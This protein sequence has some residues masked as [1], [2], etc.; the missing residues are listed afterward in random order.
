MTG[1]ARGFRRAFLLVAVSAAVLI[2]ARA[3]LAF[4]DVPTSYWDY[5]AIRYV[6]TTNTWM[7]DYGTTT[8]KP[9][10]HEI[11]EYLAR[12]LVEVYAPTEPI[13]PS[14]HFPDLPDSD[15]F[16][17]YANVVTKLGWMPKYQ[18]GNWAPG[19]LI[20]RTGFDKAMVLALG[21]TDE[22]NGLA[23]IHRDDGAKYTVST[24]FPYL[25]LARTLE[26]HFNHTT[27]SMDLEPS[28][29]MTRDEAAYS[30][31]FAK[32]QL[33][34]ELTT[35]AMFKDISLPTL[36]PTDPLQHSKLL[37]TQYALNQVGYPYIW[38][39]EWHS[40]SPSGYC[41]GYQPK[42]GFDC[43]GFAWWVLKKNESGYNAAQFRSYSG[44]LLPQRT[45][46][47]MAEST[48]T[49]YTYANLRIGDLMFFASNGGNTWQDV[50][51]VGMYVGN[52]WMIDSTGSENG[53]TIDFVAPGTWWND[54]FVW[55]RRLINGGPTDSKPQGH[56]T[57]A[58]LLGGDAK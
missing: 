52:G 16:Y 27:E 45:S 12:T 24:D 49:H 51:H 54:H 26:L 58:S 28:D 19:A 48:G 6:A 7:Q 29:Y 38:G 3:A 44:W 17:R 4:T 43:S 56:V 32:T 31:W 14:I 25:L 8:F 10:T 37:V 35:A 46:S 33:S 42:G 20:Q 2:P 50:D 36:T 23:N 18:S 22:V 53:P 57:K 30:L 9:T 21:L 55:G 11:R 41:C 5:T 15:P 47:T 39:G 40:V 13:D 34:W 1:M